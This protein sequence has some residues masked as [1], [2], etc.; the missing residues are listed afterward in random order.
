MVGNVDKPTLVR[1]VMDWRGEVPV[2]CAVGDDVEAISPRI[3]RN[4]AMVKIQEGCNQVCAYCIV[5][6]VRGREC[7]I[8]PEAMINEINRHIAQGYQE[9]VL[10]GT[11]LGSYGFDLPNMTLAQLLK[12][13]L[14]ET[15]IVRLRVSSLQPQ[16]ISA[17]MIRRSMPEV[18]ITTDVIVGFPGETDDEFGETYTLCE[19]T[20]F[21]SAHVFPYSVRPGTS[22]AYF[23]GQVPSDVKSQRV[24]A[25]LRLVDTQA[26]EFRRR[27]LGKVRP[28]LWEETKAI[29]GLTYWSGLTDNYIRVLGRSSRQLGNQITPARLWAQKEDLV[30]TQVL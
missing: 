19:Q 2:P 26:V 15:D 21:A 13:I 14:S 17:E 25:L 29:N 18:S 30:Y 4:R 16:E 1:H 12:L 22:A 6:K 9:V 5:P 11:Q 27:F 8:P 3:L 28:V 10:T 24:H 23:G 7:S 20:G